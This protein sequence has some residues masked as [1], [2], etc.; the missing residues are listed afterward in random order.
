[1]SNIS[2]NIS[3]EEIKK[4]YQQYAMKNGYKETP[5]DII[6]FLTDDY[7]LGKVTNNGKG[8]YKYW[9]DLLI[10][11]FPTPFPELNKTRNNAY[12]DNWIIIN[13][14]GIG[15]GKCHQK[16]QEIEVYM[17]EKDIKKLG[18]EEYVIDD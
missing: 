4:L 12:S 7:Y 10:K 13:S 9:L 1:M 11:I 6:T 15:T 8:V 16:S 3:Y 14:S 5:P 18:L 17:D 2:S